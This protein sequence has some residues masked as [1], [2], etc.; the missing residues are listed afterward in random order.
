MLR[1]E[2]LVARFV[3]DLL[4]CIRE[5]ALEGLRA[6]LGPDASRPR[7]LL[8]RSRVGEPDRLASVRT[9]PARAVGKPRPRPAVAPETV[10]ATTPTAAEITNPQGLLAMGQSAPPGPALLVCVAEPTPA[11]TSGQKDEGPASGVGA[12]VV[13]LPVRLREGETL[14]RDSGAGIVF[15]R[16]RSA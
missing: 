9:R 14:L 12:V 5:A 10:T 1:C 8:A 16:A 7:P 13:A 2:L 3:D 4:R 11:S 6:A 15:R